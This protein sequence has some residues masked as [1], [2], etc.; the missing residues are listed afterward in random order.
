MEIKNIVVARYLDGRVL[1]GVTRDFSPNRGIFHVDQQEG[2]QT[3]EVRFKQ[4]KALFFVRSL[5]GDP[6]RQD[7]RGFVLGPAETQQGKKIAV[8][9]RDGEFVCGYTLSWS[10]DREGFFL[11]PADASSNNQ[12][13]FVITAGTLEVKA[14]PAAEVLAQRV[15]TEAPTS[16]DAAAPPAPGQKPGS[17]TPLPPMSATR[18]SAIGRRPSGFLPRPRRTGPPSDRRTG[19]D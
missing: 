8:R 5:D 18:P 11:F 1:K 12:R 13:I 10:P 6:A 3:V 19:T 4:L 15:L 2:G 16:G 14:G 17:V 7:V 9:F